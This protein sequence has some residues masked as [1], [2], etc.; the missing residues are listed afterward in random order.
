MENADAIETHYALVAQYLSRFPIKLQSLLVGEVGSYTELFTRS[1]ARLEQK[2]HD[3]VARLQ[4][5]YHQQNWAERL[6]SSME[7][8]EQVGARIIPITST[9]YPQLLKQISSAPPILYSRGAINNLHLPQIAIVGSRRMTRGGEI[10]A[11]QW[12]KFLASN[13]FTITSGLALGVDG[14]A[15]RGALDAPCGKTVAVMATGTETIYPRR[16]AELAEH[17]L[18]SGGTLISE[19]HPNEKP[20]PTNFPRRNRIISGLSLA[21]LVIE[22]AIK[23]GSLITARYAL[24]QNREVFAIPGSIHSPQSRGCHRLIKQGAHLVETAKDIVAE[25]GGALAGVECS[26]KE[27]LRPSAE[28]N[29]QESGLLA[30]MGFESVTLDCLSQATELPAETLSQLLVGLELKGI[31]C[32]ENGFYQ[33]FP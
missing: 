25:L 32:Q 3:T 11:R 16:H 9:D 15:H 8:A 10:N 1:P 28:L 27:A 31:V 2:F 6:A 18:K 12:S 23:S 13:G 4:E 19:F 21:V 33:Q 20:L 17:I 24:E 14:C 29:Q 7:V 5:E 30:I 26:A 22:A